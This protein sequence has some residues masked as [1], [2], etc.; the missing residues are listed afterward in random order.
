MLYT[1]CSESSCADGER[2]EDGPLLRDPAGNLYGTTNF[3]GASGW[4]TVFKLDSAGHETVLHSFTGGSDGAGPFAGLTMDKAGDLYG[5]AAIGGDA[6][7][8]LDAQG[9]GVV[10]RITP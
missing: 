8:A 5:T 9:C 10:F 2:P 7:C 1:F 4:G 6:K 3:G